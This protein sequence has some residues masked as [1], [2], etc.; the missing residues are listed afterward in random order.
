MKAFALDQLG[1][2]ES[3]RLADMAMPEPKVGEVRV[4]VEAVALNPVDYKVAM[5][6]HPLWTF[7]FIPGLD[8][9]GSVD[10]IGA[11]VAGWKAGER[12]YYHGDLRKPGGFAEYAIVDHR[13][14]SRIPDHVAAVAAAALPTAAFTAYQA[15]FSKVCP[16]ENRSI[17][18]H[19]GAGGV[20]GFALQ[21]AKRGGFSTILTT[22]SPKNAE[23]V[24]TLGADHAID[25][26]GDVKA[27]VMR[28]TNGR[29]LDMI[30][31]TVGPASATG[32]FEMLAFGGDLVCIAGLPDFSAWPPFR[33]GASVH[34]IALGAAHASEDDYSIRELGRIGDE[35]I[36]MVADKTLNPMVGEI[37]DFTTLPQALARLKR[38]EVP[39]GK[40][41]VRVQQV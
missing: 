12:V 32:G 22:A 14:L 29:G 34:E 8:V 16:R 30:V 24:K 19:G 4:R 18:I 7:P 11:D 23:T 37:A 27:E 10:Q 17:L 20:G 5:R 2:P 33:L 31:N 26:H 6:G 13:A 41:V 9:A 1:E 40:V 21:F 35:V 3:L 15:I 28:L 38:R 39:A 25:Y 36:G